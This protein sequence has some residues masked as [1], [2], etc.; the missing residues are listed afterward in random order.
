MKEK[1]K[2]FYLLCKKRRGLKGVQTD[3]MVNQL[4]LSVAVG[5]LIVNQTTRLAEELNWLTITPEQQIL[6]IDFY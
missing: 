2:D 4:N 6:K 5:S 3:N 1:K